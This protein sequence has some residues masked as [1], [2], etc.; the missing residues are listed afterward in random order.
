MD[1]P[2]L[3]ELRLAFLDSIE[4]LLA[5]LL[6]LICQLFTKRQAVY[7]PEH[8]E[9]RAC[10]SLA[11]YRG[12]KATAHLTQGFGAESTF[13]TSPSPESARRLMF[14]RTTKIST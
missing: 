9:N 5:C 8:L 3:G 13:E 12:D 4:E 14:K 1:L 6:V 11:K 2:L 7:Y 10:E